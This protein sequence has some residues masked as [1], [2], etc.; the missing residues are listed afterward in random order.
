MLMQISCNSTAVINKETPLENEVIL[1]QKFKIN[2]PENHQASKFTWCL[3]DDYNK[4]I[5]KEINTVWRGNNNG[6]DFVFEST[7]K[8]KTILKFNSRFYKDTS[9]VKSFII[10]VK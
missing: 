7:E 4:A 9:E 6:V 5:I 1:G 2:L 8:G 3:A 10:S